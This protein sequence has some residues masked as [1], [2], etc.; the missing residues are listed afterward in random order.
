MSPRWPRRARRRTRTRR[1]ILLVVA[2]ILLALL[3]GGLTQVARQSQGYD[4]DS[5]RT[6]AA[7]GGL[8][9]DQSNA[10][11]LAVRTLLEDLPTMARQS[12]QAALDGAVRQTAAESQEAGVAMGNTPAGSSGSELT[13]VFTER[14]QSMEDLRG[15]LD[16]LL[17]MEPSAVTGAPASRTVPLPGPA[18]SLSAGEAADR[19]TVAG[20][21]LSRSDA[22]YRSVRRTLAASAGHARLPRSVW[23]ADPQ[24]WQAGS[25]AALVDQVATSPTL[26][27]SHY[28]VLR[29]VRL[30]PPVL[31]PVSGAP[32]GVA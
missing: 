4:A 20:A 21:L 7:Q 17:G 28:V 30:T 26:E 19:I 16:G 11:S 12:L 8:L 5:N 15:A 18:A 27:P 32:A 3:V 29:T 24:L 25:V 9:A 13:A 31:P 10:T 2:V 1:V 14:A 6:L 23:V 22:L